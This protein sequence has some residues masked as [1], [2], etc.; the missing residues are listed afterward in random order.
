[1][2]GGAVKHDLAIIIHAVCYPLLHAISEKIG[3]PRFVL[4]R[5]ESIEKYQN[6]ELL[7]KM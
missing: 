2:V 3:D 1:M 4:S 7:L 5:K 6:F